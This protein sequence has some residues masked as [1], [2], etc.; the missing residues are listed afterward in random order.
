MAGQASMITRRA[1]QRQF[2]LRP[3]SE[4]NQTFL[5]ALAL[6]AE[7]TGVDV[8]LPSVQ[9]NHHHTVTYDRH[10]RLVE[11]YQYLHTLTA[12][13][14]N[15][16]RGRFE[17]FWAT[18]QT[19]VVRLVG[20]DDLVEKIVY[21][22]TN[23]VKDGLVAKV[24]HWPGVN[25][26]R[27]LLD[28]RTITVKRPRHFFRD[29]G[30]LPEQVTLT[31]GIPSELGNV[32]EI[33]ATVRRRVAEVEEE[34]AAKRARTGATV[35]GRRAVCKQS[36]RDR[37]RSHEPRFGLRPRVAARN[38]WARIEAL[39]RNAAFVEAYRAARALWLAGQLTLFPPGTYWLRRFANV[40]VAAPPRASP[41]AP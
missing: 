41:S 6:A 40:P 36:W 3:D 33:L 38:K 29:D 12:R 17:N 34:Q 32:E 31:L 7:R 15:A 11:F 22:A 21:A 2:L 25:G 5:Y 19:S 16:W 23:P 35:L 30:D 27:A 37:P 4:T 13:A 24:H 28:R 18:E 20:V 26:L 14:M 10:G 1:T 9:A 39:Q 8:I